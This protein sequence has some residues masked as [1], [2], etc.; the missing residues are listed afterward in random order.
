LS[1]ANKAQG[2]GS[3]SRIAFNF[4]KLR[5]AD[6]TIKQGERESFLGVNVYS[7]YLNPGG[8]TKKAMG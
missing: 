4:E 1:N 8:K 6:W 5:E 3:Q 2:S 7:C